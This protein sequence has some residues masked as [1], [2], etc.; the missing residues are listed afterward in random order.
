MKVGGV[1]PFLSFWLNWDLLLCCWWSDLQG[2][3]RPAFIFFRNMKMIV[4]IFVS[5]LA[6]G[7]SWRRILTWDRCVGTEAWLVIVACVARIL[8]MCFI[9]TLL[10]LNLMFVILWVLVA[11]LRSVLALWPVHRAWLERLVAVIRGSLVIPLLVTFVIGVTTIAVT[12]ILPL[13]V[14]MMVLVVPLVVT[15]VTS[16]TLFRHMAD[17]LIVP[18]A[19][20]VTHLMSHAL[21]DLMFAFLSQGVIC[22]LWI[23][24]VLKVLC[25]W[26]ERLLAKTSAAFN[27]LCPVFLMERHI[28]PFKL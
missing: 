5:F 26:L 22:Y 16:V 1:S 13:E 15:T 18:L 28:E 10:V 14:V 2:T 8:M 7:W 17:L 27:V 20:F 3:W 24:D 11:L 21:F 23:E 19:K 6:L 9:V 4:V 12:M 25:E